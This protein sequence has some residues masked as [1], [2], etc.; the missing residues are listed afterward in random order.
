MELGLSAHRRVD[1]LSE[2]RPLTQRAVDIHHEGLNLVG[3]CDV[4]RGVNGQFLVPAGGQLEVPTCWG[5]STDS[6]V[7]LASFVSGFAHS[8]GVAVGDDGVAV[9]Q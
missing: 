5:S 7:W 3:R 4:V 1:D 6:M 9:M 2:G 8:V